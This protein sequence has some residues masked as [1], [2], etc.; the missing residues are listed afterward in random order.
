M[1]MMRLAT[2]PGSGVTNADVLAFLE[3][4]KARGLLTPNDETLLD[5]YRQ[6]AAAQA[7]PGAAQ[8]APQEAAK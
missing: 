4:L 2:L 3:S 1:P 7:T 6:K 8:T 5:S